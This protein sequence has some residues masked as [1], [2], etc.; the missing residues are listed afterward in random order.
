MSIQNPK[1]GIKDDDEAPGLVQALVAR[2]RE[3][4]ILET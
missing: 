2:T 4:L 1:E 3:A